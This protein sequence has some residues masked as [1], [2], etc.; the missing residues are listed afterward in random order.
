MYGLPTPDCSASADVKR[1]EGPAG[2][3]YA[4]Q[5]TFRPNRGHPWPGSQFPVDLK[6]ATAA[7]SAP[8]RAD[9]PVHGPVSSSSTMTVPSSLRAR[10]P[11]ILLR[12]HDSDPSR[13]AGNGGA[14]P[15]T[16]TTAVV[17]TDGHHGSVDEFLIILTGQAEI[18]G[19]FTGHS[20][21]ALANQ[22]SRH[23]PLNFEVGSEQQ[24]LATIGTDHLTVGSGRR[25]RLPAQVILYP[26]WQ[27]TAARAIISAGSLVASIITYLRSRCYRGGWIPLVPGWCRRLIMAIIGVTTDSVHR[28]L[29]AC[30]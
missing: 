27:R 14:A 11:E 26:I 12:L 23:K 19:N 20:A 13:L 8:R 24:I 3:P 10:V 7:W 15:P 2:K 28:L 21:Y 30:P 6:S 18:T 25:D 16:V 1:V 9:R 22:L 4:A 17:L 5:T 29:R